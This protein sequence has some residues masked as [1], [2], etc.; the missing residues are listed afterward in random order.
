MY[1]PAQYVLKRFS[2][3][4][5]VLITFSS[6][7]ALKIGAKGQIPLEKLR[8]KQG[9]MLAK[10]KNAVPAGPLRVLTYTLEQVTLDEPIVMNRNLK[11]TIT[12]ALRLKISLNSFISGSYTI[13][14]DDQGFTAVPISDTELTAV[15]LG[16]YKLQ[17]GAT[18]SVARGTACDIRDRSLVPD[19]LILP[20]KLRNKSDSSDDRGNFVRRIRHLPAENKEKASIEVELAISS[21]VQ[22]QNEAMVLQIGD[23]N[24][25]MDGYT[26][27]PHKLRFVL[28]SDDFASLNNGSP[29]TVKYGRCSFLGI[30]FGSL[31][32]A[33]LGQ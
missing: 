33:L 16:D 19:K 4:L 27:D 2:L 9:R 18:I 21:P 30:R 31:N 12:D 3:G 10:G 20:A 28:S 1:L 22:V 11:L 17:D 32:K 25:A 5:L 14:I 15:I 7:T 6:A 23:R 8:I 24:F 13:W 29:I 26:P